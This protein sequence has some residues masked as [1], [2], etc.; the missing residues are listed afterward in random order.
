MCSGLV[1]QMPGP[2]YEGQLNLIEH[3]HDQLLTSTMSQLIIYILK[4]KECFINC[5][6]P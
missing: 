3:R 5:I 2:A 6:T 1:N 4:K